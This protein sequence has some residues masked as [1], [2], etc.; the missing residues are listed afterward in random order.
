MNE[1]L[2]QIHD[3][4]EN[5]IQIRFDGKKIGVFAPSNIKSGKNGKLIALSLS[6]IDEEQIKKMIKEFGK[7]NEHEI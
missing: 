2:S 7:C 5:E 6:N 4:P 3:Y 1:T